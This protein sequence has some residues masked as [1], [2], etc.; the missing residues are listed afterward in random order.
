MPLLAN[1]DGYLLS[2]TRRLVM[3]SLASWEMFL[4]ALLM[5]LYWLLMILFLVRSMEST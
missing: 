1:N 3:K 5:K 4:N 2:L